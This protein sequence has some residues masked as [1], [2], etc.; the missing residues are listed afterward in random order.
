MPPARRSAAAGEARAS[1]PSFTWERNCGAKFDFGGGGVCGTASASRIIRRLCHRFLNQSNKLIREQ[2]CPKTQSSSNAECGAAFALWAEKRWP[3]QALLRTALHNASSIFVRFTR[4]VNVEDYFEVAVGREPVQAR[5]K[6]QPTD[7]PSG[8]LSR[9]GSRRCFSENIR[10]QRTAAFKMVEREG[11]RL[12]SRRSVAEP[13]ASS[14]T[15][16]KRLFRSGDFRAAVGQRSQH[17]RWWSVRE[18]RLGSGCA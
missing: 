8:I 11:Q 1:F 12:G 15:S 16:A 18:H 3:K 9:R 10:R 7:R 5:G 14:Q 13:G 2:N 4:G 6:S 17:A